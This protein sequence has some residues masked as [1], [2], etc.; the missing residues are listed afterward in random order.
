MKN[1]HVRLHIGKIEKL[2]ESIYRDKNCK[3]VPII[4]NKKAASFE[5]ATFYGWKMGL[6]GDAHCLLL[7]LHQIKSSFCCFFIDLKSLL[8]QAQT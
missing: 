1:V 4:A 7:G 6:L 3:Q 5:A 8:E 2:N